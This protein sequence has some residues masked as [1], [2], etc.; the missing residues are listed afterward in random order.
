M[1][2]GGRFLVCLVVVGSV[3]LVVVLYAG[4]GEVVFGILSVVEWLC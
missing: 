2:L 3:V 1:I 4:V